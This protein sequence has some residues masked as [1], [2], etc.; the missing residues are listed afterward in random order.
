[1][2]RT[3]F[4]TRL[5]ASILRTI[6]AIIVINVGIWCGTASVCWRQ[7]APNNDF[8]VI[9][10]IMMYLTAGIIICFGVYLISP[11]YIG[12]LK[13]AIIDELLEKTSI[14]VQEHDNS[15]ELK[16]IRRKIRRL[17]ETYIW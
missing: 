6:I 11:I 16:K 14:Q 12:A 17:K 8:G 3:K 1:M 2:Q 7:W 13:Y 9:I 15:S 4:S 5:I 10:V